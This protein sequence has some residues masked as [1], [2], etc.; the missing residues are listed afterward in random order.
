MEIKENIISKLEKILKNMK[1]KHGVEGNLDVNLGTMLEKSK[2]SSSDLSITCFALAK[3]FRKSPIDIANEIA[4]NLEKENLNYIEKIEVIKGYVNIFL[5]REYIMLEAVRN[6]SKEKIGF[7]KENEGKVVLIDYSSPNIAKQFHIGHL[8]TTVIGGMFAKLFRALRIY[9]E[10]INHLG[11]YGTQ[12]GK[13]I[14]GYN[15]WKDEYT[16]DEHPIEDLTDIY[17]RI[18]KLCRRR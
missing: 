11:D 14:E 2:G 18:N 12:F 8:K 6:V 15:L 4:E 1:E 17:V 13:L 7:N 16:F 3:I 10:G 9:I 5:N